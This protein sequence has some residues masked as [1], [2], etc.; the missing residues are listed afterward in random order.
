M[1][2]HDCREFKRILW[3]VDCLCKRER[4]HGRAKRM[5]TRIARA[6]LKERTF[7]EWQEAA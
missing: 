7:R 6:R 1:T 3:T 5:V 4:P 2:C